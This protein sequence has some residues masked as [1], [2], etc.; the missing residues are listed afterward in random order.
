MLTHYPDAEEA[1]PGEACPAS[2]EVADRVLHG[3]LLGGM[4]EGRELARGA[5]DGA[6]WLQRALDGNPLHHA[7]SRYLAD[8]EAP[9]GTRFDRYV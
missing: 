9:V 6:R 1:A 2:G 4:S 5:G 8:L 3:E 7:L